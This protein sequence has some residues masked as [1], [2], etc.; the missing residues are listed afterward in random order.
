MIINIYSIFTLY[1][2][3][4][5]LFYLIILI[6]NVIYIIFNLNYILP[7]II[8]IIYLS[9]NDF[10]YISLRFDNWFKDSGISE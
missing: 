3:L 6:L 8:N 1:L 10:I 9:L 2:F 4:L 7:I 5:N